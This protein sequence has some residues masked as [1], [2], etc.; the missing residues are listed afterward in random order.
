MRVRGLVSGLVLLGS[1]CVL[2]GGSS[3][4]SQSPGKLLICSN[5]ADP[6]DVMGRTYDLYVASGNGAV[7]A[8]LTDAFGE[9]CDAEWSP[10]GKRIAFV[11]Y[12]HDPDASGFGNGEL[13]VMNADGS[14]KTRLT[15]NGVPDRSPT[16]SPDGR[17]IAFSRTG[18]SESGETEDLYVMNADGSGVTKLATGNLHNTGPSWSPD[19]TRIAF[20]S[21]AEVGPSYGG[22]SLIDP[23]G[24][25]LVEL[26]HPPAAA[27]DYFP[28]WSPDG[29]RVAF[30]RANDIYVVNADGTGEMLLFATDNLAG[31]G[32]ITWSPDGTRIAFG[33]EVGSGV[34]VYAVN[35]DGSGETLLLG[36]AAVE[37]PL[38]WRASAWPGDCTIAGT[39]GPDELF[40]TAGADVICGFGGGDLLQGAAGND[41]LRGGK[42]NDRLFGEAG[43]DRLEGGPGRDYAHGGAAKDVCVAET[44]RFC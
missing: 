18:S 31:W 26:T 5:R 17:Q 12:R 41:V 44:R 28:S 9:D 8:R 34:D 39:P 14:K 15:A 32:R 6:T 23:D 43:T 2:A 30:W 35:A 37:M 19:G 7:I 16:W 25:G 13:Y 27:G 40:G 4:I 29:T 10:N 42:G 11:S 24:S 3:A 38:D 33:K 36:Q 22:I 21:W 20:H 1:V